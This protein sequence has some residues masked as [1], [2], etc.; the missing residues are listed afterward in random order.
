MLKIIL[1]TY[2]EFDAEIEGDEPAFEFGDKNFELEDPEPEY[3]HFLMRKRL[4]CFPRLLQ[5]KLMT[6]TFNDDCNY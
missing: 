4:S 2:K 6:G 1:K 3:L 5:N